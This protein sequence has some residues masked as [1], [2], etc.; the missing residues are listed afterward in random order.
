MS[1]TRRE[2]ETAHWALQERRIELIRGLIQSR[3]T[4]L[5]IITSGLRLPPIRR[6][7]WTD[8]SAGARKVYDFFLRDDLHPARSQNF[9][10]MSRGA[11]LQLAAELSKTSL[12]GCRQRISL[13]EKL[14]IFLFIATSGASIRMASELF[15][16]SYTGVKKAFHAVILALMELYDE[17]VNI[18]T[19]ATSN[20]YMQ[21]NFGR[22]WP[23][24]KDCIGAIDGTHIPIS[25]ESITESYRN[26]KG[27]FSQNV[28]ACCDWEMNFTYI[29]A[30]VEGSAHDCKALFEADVNGRFR[31]LIPEGGFFLADAGYAPS[32]PKVLTPYV[33]TRYHL[34]E[35]KALGATPQN[36]KE[37]YNLRHSSRRTVIERA[38]GLFKGRFK[39]YKGNT[40]N[41]FAKTVQISLLYALVCLHNFMNKHREGLDES[42]EPVMSEDLSVDDFDEDL[43][44]LSPTTKR[45]EIARSMWIEYMNWTN[46]G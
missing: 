33:G 22:C 30:G 4:A 20:V 7:L 9:T 39:I 2:L 15:Q 1:P 17:Y 41:P 18:P 44:S 26:R 13:Q 25:G 37:L 3:S 45:D 43:F 31:E 5:F 27:W 29:Y 6:A 16:H 34:Q 46:D 42:D 19:P 10:R 32:H 23:Y 12:K 28:V 8:S 14:L 35:Y 24:F 40:I 11:L 21:R 38:F 36:A